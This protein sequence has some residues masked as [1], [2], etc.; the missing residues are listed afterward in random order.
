MRPL[1]V[2]VAELLRQ[3]GAVRRVETVV[4]LDELDARG[5]RLSGPAAVDLMLESTLDDIVLTGTLA[6]AWR[7]TCRRCLRPLADT[8]RIDV[9]ERVDAVNGQV[10]LTAI[11]RDELLLGPPDAPLCRADCPGL[12]PICGADLAE[13]PCGCTTSARDERWAVL[14]E[15]RDQPG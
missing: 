6:V 10:D 13:G 15:L 14:D 1:V 12:C 11:A 7:D 2:N 8:L 5:D 9:D 4:D 3:P